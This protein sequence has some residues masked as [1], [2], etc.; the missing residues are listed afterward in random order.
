MKKF[1][2]TRP[3]KQTVCYG[4]TP[5]LIGKPSINGGLSSSKYTKRYG[6]IHQF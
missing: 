1:R 3:G 2:D 6:K 5:I 4:K